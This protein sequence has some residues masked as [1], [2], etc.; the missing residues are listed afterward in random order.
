[1]TII[2]KVDSLE[3]RFK[4]NLFTEENVTLLLTHGLTQEIL[5][6]FILQTL[7]SVFYPELI[8]VVALIGFLEIINMTVMAR[9]IM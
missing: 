2:F 5:S 8:S 7:I 4:T 9:K 6:R 3:I 1:M